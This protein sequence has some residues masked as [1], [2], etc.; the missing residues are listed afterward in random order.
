[1]L[2]AGI[3]MRR[4]QPQRRIL[5]FPSASTRNS[6]VL[7]TASPPSFPNESQKPGKNSFGSFPASFSFFLP[8]TLLPGLVAVLGAAIIPDDP[9]PFEGYLEVEGK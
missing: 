1:V 3:A 9:V 6:Q 8:K 5:A 4:Y 2:T 7:H